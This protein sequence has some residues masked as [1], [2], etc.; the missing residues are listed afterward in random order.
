MTETQRTILV[1]DDDAAQRSL[2]ADFVGSLDFHTPEA[3][4]A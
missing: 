4:S 3:G 1:V 2:L